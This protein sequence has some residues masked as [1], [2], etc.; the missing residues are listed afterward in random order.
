MVQPPRNP[1]LTRDNWNIVRK[2]ISEPH[3]TMTEDLKTAVKDG[4]NVINHQN[5][6]RHQNSIEKT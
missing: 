4:L 2:K 1:D 6:R 3:P 5:G